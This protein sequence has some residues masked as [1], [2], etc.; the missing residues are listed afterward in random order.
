[1]NKKK[2]LSIMFSILFLFGLGSCASSGGSSSSDNS[3]VVVSNEV[4]KSDVSTE[5]N[6]KLQVINTSGSERNFNLE[7]SGSVVDKEVKNKDKEVNYDKNSSKIINLSDGSSSFIGSGVK[8]DGNNIMITEAGVYVL[9]GNLKDG[10][11]IVE[12]GKEDDVRLVLENVNIHSE[13]SAAIYVK[14]ADKLIVTLPKGTN[15]TL[16]GGI[17]Y[18]NIDDNNIDGVIFSK[19]DLTING[20]GVLNINANYKHAIVSKNDLNIIGGTYNIKSVSQALSGKDAVKIYGGDFSIESQGKGIK[21]ENTEE[22]EKG[23]IYIAGG[24]FNLNTV[25]DGLHSSGSIVLDGGEFKIKSKDDA[26]HSDK[27]IV[28]NNG[29]LNIEESYEGLEGYRVTLNGG[30]VNVNSSDDGINAANPNSNPT[31]S[32]TEAKNAENE[33]K[34]QKDFQNFNMDNAGFRHGNRKMNPE[35]I[36]SNFTGDMSTEIFEGRMFDGGRRGGFGADMMDDTNAYIKIT[37]GKLIINAGG[38]GIDSNGSILVTGGSTFISSRTNTQDTAI[39]YNGTIKI[40]GG[41]FIAVGGNGM[42]GDFTSQK[43]GQKSILYNL[44]VQQE[45]NSVVKITDTNG[46]EILSWNPTMEYK[47]VIVSSPNLKEN[48][49]YKLQ[50]GNESFDLMIKD[51]VTTNG[52]S[53]GRGHKKNFNHNHHNPTS[54]NQNISGQSI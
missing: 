29:N 51:V 39:D 47:M 49:N 7:L 28:I 13:K 37:G 20:D 30:S 8:V 44:A 17:S 6:A 14:N 32:S 15:N 25:D 1:M 46:K 23:N 9:N 35:Q 11:V 40:D 12:V 45:K 53:V 16:S 31:T 38:D 2:M 10:Q 50:A 43:S 52:M 36:P 42:M 5:I 26:I 4:P 27:D 22:G 24:R 41:D 19:D 3:S 48:Q 21:S 54:T 33:T 34:A 18:E